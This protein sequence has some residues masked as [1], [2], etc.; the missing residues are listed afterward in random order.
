MEDNDFVS[1]AALICEPVRAKMLWKLLDGRA[2]TATELALFAGASTSSAS[3]HLS[4]LLSNDLLKVDAQGRHRYY[5]F[6]NED[7]AYAVE[8]LANLAQ[9]GTHKDSR[10]IKPKKGIE[11]CRSCYDHLAGY[12]GV[13][14]TDTL[15]KRNYLKL[16]GDAYQVT[17]E[18]W[19]WF[20]QFGISKSDFAKKRRPLTRQCL[21][22]SERR[23]H[24]AGQLGAVLLDLAIREDWFRKVSFS[25]ELAVT[26]K[27]R[28]TLYDLLGISL[29]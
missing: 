24:L 4:K 5:T 26:S 15:V 1:L 19:Y 6:A 9:A 13:V 7:V 18:G 3:N 12:V 8:A 22:W 27:G 11:Y 21:D 17:G 20:A 23:P 16:T 29:P 2:Y 14:L 25:R 28:G 10:E